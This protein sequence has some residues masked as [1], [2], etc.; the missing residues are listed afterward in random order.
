[1]AQA[2]SGS[3]AASRVARGPERAS[4]EVEVRLLVGIGPG[5]GD[6]LVGPSPGGGEA[7]RESDV[8]GAPLAVFAGAPPGTALR[9]ALEAAGERRVFFHNFSFAGGFAGARALL[10]AA[11][12]AA[13]DHD[14]LEV[15]LELLGQDR[16]RAPASATSAWRMCCQPCSA[17]LPAATGRPA[18]RR[19]GPAERGEHWEP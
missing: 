2:L 17:P 1:M 10:P 8:L 6:D 16:A 18:A 11:A 7:W 9:F 3:V 15:R 14:A 19:G 12:D 13:T 4:A 5:P